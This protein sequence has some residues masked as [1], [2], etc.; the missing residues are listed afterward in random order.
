MRAV[1]ERC[2]PLRP[3][4]TAALVCLAA[5][6]CRHPQAATPAGKGARFVSIKGNVQVKKAGTLPWS[7]AT[8]ETVVSNLDR[9]STGANS[10]ARLRFADGTELNIRPDSVMEIQEDAIDELSR[11]RLGMSLEHGELRFKTPAQPGQRRVETPAGRAAPEHGSEGSVQVGNSGDTAISVF[12]GKSR[13]TPRSGGAID[14]AAGEGL[15]IDRSGK[16]GGKQLLPAIPV[17]VA[18]TDQLELRYDESRE[19]ATLLSWQSVAGAGSYRVVLEPAAGAS[20]GATES[21]VDATRLAVRG[22]EPGGYCWQV[23]AIDAG[24]VEGGFSAQWCFFVGAGTASVMKPPALVVDVVELRGSQLHIKGRTDAGVLLSINGERVPVQSDG[25][26][27]EHVALRDKAKAVAI[28]AEGG[29]GAVTEQQLP[30]VA[31]Q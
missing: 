25:S 13:V 11:P 8:L 27:N 15:S 16:A 14:V 30:I 23:A 29:S 17:L 22:L 20:G 18:P 3:L 21:R 19:A 2:L 5:L 6:A 4:L 28:R 24:G 1:S 12:T 7:D 10:A 31:P 26:F 9:V